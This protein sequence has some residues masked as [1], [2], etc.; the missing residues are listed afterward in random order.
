MYCV[1]PSSATSCLCFSS[2]AQALAAALER[3]VRGASASPSSSGCIGRSKRGRAPTPDEL[4]GA[5]YGALSAMGMEVTI[6][7]PARRGRGS[8]NPGLAT[9]RTLSFCASHDLDT[10]RR[11]RSSPRPT[12]RVRTLPRRQRQS[13]RAP[14]PPDAKRASC[15]VTGPRPSGQSICTDCANKRLKSGVGRIA[16]SRRSAVPAI[17]GGQQ[18]RFSTSVP[19]TA[20]TLPNSFCAMISRFWQKAPPAACH[21]AGSSAA[22]PRSPAGRF[23]HKGAGHHTRRTAAGM[24]A[25]L[26]WRQC[27][28]ARRVLA[29]TNI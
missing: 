9:G 27:R 11:Y 29:R 21:R 2:T 4:T 23:D 8:Q 5:L 25:I 3:A 26:P 16:G 12:G 1:T 22:P 19:S 6:A 15:K 17:V 10:C 13:T 24:S 28:H 7:G 20:S 14:A 18:S